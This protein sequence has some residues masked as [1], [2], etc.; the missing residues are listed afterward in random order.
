MNPYGA[1]PSLLNGIGVCFNFAIECKP[2][3]HSLVPI[4]TKG[5]GNSRLT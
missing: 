5:F 2:R 1:P 3:A 4:K